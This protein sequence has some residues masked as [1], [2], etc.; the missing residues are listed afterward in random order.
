MAKFYSFPHINQYTDMIKNVYSVTRFNGCDEAGKPL[1]DTTR[2]L[3][4]IK[5]TGTVKVHG[6]N[7]G[8]GYDPISKTVWAQSRNHVLSDKSDNCGFHTF[9][10]LNKDIFIQRVEHII[11]YNKLAEGK[12]FPNSFK[13]YDTS[14]TKYK[15]SADRKG[16]IFKLS[17]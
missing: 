16:F 12:L 1:F 14:F 7:A 11:T 9:V 17:K 13:D 8:I 4:T 2:P 6:T 5:F 15:S 10:M 3:P